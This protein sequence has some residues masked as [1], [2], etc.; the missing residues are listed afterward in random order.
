MKT[1]N[2]TECKVMV[3][4]VE[5]PIKTLTEMFRELMVCTPCRQFQMAIMD[6]E[7]L[8]EHLRSFR[9]DGPIQPMHEIPLADSET[10][11]HVAK[12]DPDMPWNLK[13]KAPSDFP[14]FQPGESKEEPPT[15]P[16]PEHH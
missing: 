4:A 1:T 10:L 16:S 7:G 9:E 2:E 12:N 5:E 8:T 11:E 6:L 15:V 3:S 13:S 14:P